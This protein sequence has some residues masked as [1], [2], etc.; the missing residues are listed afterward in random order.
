[1][2]SGVECFCGSFVVETLPV[3][4]VGFAMEFRDGV[5]P[6]MEPGTSERRLAEDKSFLGAVAGASVE[7]EADFFGRA[8]FPSVPDMEG[9]LFF[10]RFSSL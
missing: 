3:V 6:P 8:V 7:T 10:E 2:V 5:P 4:V 9:K 1:M